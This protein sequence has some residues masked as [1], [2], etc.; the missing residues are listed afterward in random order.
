[1]E[2]RKINIIN[3][4][5]RFAL[6]G[7]FEYGY[8]PA[9]SCLGGSE[10]DYFLNTIVFFRFIED[11]FCISSFNEKEQEQLE[12]KFG[13]RSESYE[14]YDENIVDTALEMLSKNKLV[15]VRVSGAEAYDVVTLKKT[16][17]S[18]SDHW[19]LCYGYDLKAK[20]F[21]VLEHQTNIA[22]IYKPCKIDFNNFKEAY[23][24]NKN[25]KI[26]N[27]VILWKEKEI[28]GNQA[29]GSKYCERIREYYDKFEL[30]KESLL[31]YLDV[32][33]TCAEDED[34]FPNDNILLT[35]EVIKGIQ[36]EQ[37]LMENCGFSCNVTELLKLL[38]L[39]RTFQT[40]C[41]LY[42][43]D[44]SYKMLIKY[45]EKSKEPV[46][47]YFDHILNIV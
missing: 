42:P 46:R 38:N 15:M 23:T 17:K 5:N 3:P 16:E 14:D 6:G 39:V 24:I 27:K 31:R 33:K 19:L 21:D 29:F 10:T 30:S 13:I 8:I 18:F 40:K 32:L 36:R 25:K 4:F 35:S 11:N 41:D 28:S 22:A 7:C 37:W 44:R 9:F 47:E 43:S 26:F 12:A 34:D 20:E 1:M 45:A 2:D